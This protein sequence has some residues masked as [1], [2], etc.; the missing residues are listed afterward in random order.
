MTNWQVGFFR[1]PTPENPRT[2]MS[3]SYYSNPV[4]SK[5]PR[6]ASAW[7]AFSNPAKRWRHENRDFA[8]QCEPKQADGLQM[9]AGSAIC[10]RFDADRICNHFHWFCANLLLE[11]FLCSPSTHTSS[12]SPRLLILSLVCSL[13][14][15]DRTHCKAAD[16]FASTSWLFRSPRGIFDV[17]RRY[18]RLYPCGQVWVPSKTCRNVRCEIPGRAII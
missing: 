8:S 12:S 4:A 1:T 13:I 16:R 15:S 10:R 6:R 14:R 18:Q 11:C 7:D 3:D 5:H 9:A 2:P 17:D